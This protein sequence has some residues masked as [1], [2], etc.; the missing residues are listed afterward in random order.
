MASKGP[1]LSVLDDMF[2]TVSNHLP[3]FSPW[4]LACFLRTHTRQVVLQIPTET[5]ATVLREHD[6]NV[7]ST[8]EALLNVCSPAQSRNKVVITQTLTTLLEDLISSATSQGLP[9][10]LL[11]GLQAPSP[12]NRS[13]N[14]Q[15]WRDEELARA[16]QV[17]P[18]TC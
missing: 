7:E 18:A 13:P 16:M 15:I 6:G 12:V 17:S 2:P 14:D 8:I 5:I 4:L 3:F 11:Q 10:P 9:N 1:S